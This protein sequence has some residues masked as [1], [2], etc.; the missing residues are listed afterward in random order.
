MT[1]EATNQTLDNAC[2]DTYKVVD[3]CSWQFVMK[4]VTIACIIVGILFGNSLVITSVF[5][6]QRLRRSISN[7]FIASLAIADLLVAMTVLPFSLADEVMGYWLF[8]E[9][10]C[11]TW[12]VVDIWVC[13]ASILHLCAISMDRY[14]AIA[15]PLRYPNMMT[16]RRCRLICLAMWILSFLISFP[17][18]ITWGSADSNGGLGPLNNITGN[19]TTAATPPTC[20]VTNSDDNSPGYTIYSA[21]GSFFIPSIVLCGFYIKIFLM[22][23]QFMHQSKTGTISSTQNGNSSLRVHRGGTSHKESSKNKL[24][25][26][27]HHLITPTQ[28]TADTSN[29][30]LKLYDVEMNGDEFPTRQ[31][32]TRSN[33]SHIDRTLA[34]TA[35]LTRNLS[36]TNVG[37]TMNKE[38]R[39]AKTVAIIV[40]C[41]I[42][43]W[44]PFFVSY[45]ILGVSDYEMDKQ[46]F[47]VFFWIGYINSLINPCI[48]AF[49]SI[50]YRYAFKKIL[51]CQ[52]RSAVARRHG[53]R[54]YIAS[55]YLSSSSGRTDTINSKSRPQILK[56]GVPVDTTM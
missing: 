53:M 40:G 17:A 4:T 5:L 22:A 18:L 24:C 26:E 7:S 49:F 36:R 31:S 34:A 51:R 28:L 39:A 6:Y 35:P 46:L 12:L 30:D 1:M 52:V 14:I 10:M 32:S 37:H 41:F 21:M 42:V 23:R 55:L 47:K 11:K 54:R 56:P 33:P 50:D 43:C 38:T 8:G 9:V 20:G 29:D 15:Y 19:R 27:K 16:H 25:Y 2:W 45:T 3:T 13:T 48:Y 44:A